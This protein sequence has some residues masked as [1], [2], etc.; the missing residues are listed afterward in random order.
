[1]YWAARA[2]YEALAG[3]SQF[4]VGY[5]TCPSR[6]GLGSRRLVQIESNDLRHSIASL[7]SLGFK[8]CDEAGWGV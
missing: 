6:A 7:D 2:N 1:M 5:E 8:C 3:T 4:P